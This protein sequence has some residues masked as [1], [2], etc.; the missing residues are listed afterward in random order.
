MIKK[1]LF[2]IFLFANLYV[3]SQSYSIHLQSGVFTPIENNLS[4]VRWSN[5]ELVNGYYYRFIQF[6]NI[7]TNEE[8]K[9]FA[10]HGILLYNYVPNHAFMAAIPAAFDIT[11]LKEE[12]IRSV[13]PIEKN[14]KLEVSLAKKQY[15]GW[16]LK[17]NQKIELV[18]MQHPNISYNQVSQWLR[19]EGAEVQHSIV[20][21]GAHRIIIKIS[22]IEKYA[23]LP[24]LYFLEPFD[25][26]P[27]PDNLVGRS[28]HRSNMIA[29]DYFGGLKYDGTGVKIALND[30]GVIGPHIDY[31]GR[32]I[33]QF[34]G[35]NNGNH[36]D[37]C[38]GIIMSAGNR[39]PLGRGMAFGAD[40]GVYGVSGMFSTLYQAFD[41]IYSHYNKYEIRITSTSYSNGN[42]AGYT[43]LAQLMDIHINDMPDLMHVFS[44]GNA[45]ASDFGYGAGA[46]WGNITGGH[47]QAKN[48]IATGNVTY[49]D[50]LA[51]S[52]SRGPAHD[53]RIKPD[54][55]AV[56]TNVLS[57]IDPDTYANFTGTSMAC[58]GIAGTL[59]QLYQAYKEL[60]NGNNPSSALIK[61][62]VLN[63]ADDLGN[64]GPDYKHGWGRI[65]ARRAYS[66]IKN[67]Q[68]I[69][70]MI[71]QGGNKTHIITVPNGVSELRIM[72]YWH[73]FE[74]TV[75]VSKA[76][77]NNLD[78]TVTTPS[79]QV[80][81]PW[82]L[83]PTP[84]PVNLNTPAV[85]GVDT[86]NNVEQV[87]ITNPAA[88][89]YTVTI[90]GTQVPQG[91]Q[92]YYVVYE[93]VTDDLVLTYPSGG[94]SIVPGTQETI[95]WDAFGNSG[96]FTLEYSTDNG[97]TWNTIASGIAAAQRYYD[98]N[99]PTVVTGQAL[100][101]VSR[102]AKSDVSDTNFSIIGVPSNIT[103]DWVCIDSMQVSYGA[104]SGATGY[105][106]SILGNKYM[107]SVGYSTTT[108][109]VVKNINTFNPGWFSVH[110]LGANNCVGRRAIAQPYQ[111]VPYNCVIPDDIVMLNH[112]APNSTTILNCQ[113][114]A[115]P[116]PVS[117]TIKNAGLTPASNITVKY[118][119]NGGS[120]VAEVYAG[121]INANTSVVYNFVQGATL[122]SPGNYE[123]KAW[124]EHPNNQIPTNDTTTW[125]KNVVSQPVLPLPIF[126]DFET[127][128]LCGT[129][130]NCSNENCAMSNGWLNEFNNLTD[131]IDWRTNSGPTPTTNTGPAMDF[132]PGTLDGKY[133]YIEA[134]SCFNKPAELISPCIEIASN[135][136]AP[137]MSFAYHMW[138]SDMG[139][140]HVDVFSDGVWNNDVIP[141]FTGD[142]GN[143][144]NTAVV[145]LSAYIGK[146]INIR[147]R[148]ISG[149]NFNS[150]MAL[151]AISIT[152]PVGLNN[153]EPEM[154]MQLFPNPTNGLIYLEIYRVPSETEI[155]ITDVNG[156][157]VYK[158]KVQP[159][160]N[161]VN[162]TINLENTNAG[163]YFITIKNN[164]GIINK[165]LLKF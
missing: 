100:V 52:S 95:R 116:F 66:I 21:Q 135:L 3:F 61:A 13:F 151:D 97:N 76:L 110:A 86:L 163:I 140:L 139:E 17:T 73:D 44:A 125:Y 84:N 132:L 9:Y 104:V 103:V 27:Q 90:N 50:V 141:V 147:F 81:L 94:E 26:N 107:D 101:R 137:E 160:G 70:D 89:N 6:K 126:E 102:G 91:P 74:A 33:N 149:A 77:V 145:P 122:S 58:P 31:Q 72:V 32:L 113:P 82:V 49:Q 63:T 78:L 62:S 152:D 164:L 138:G 80:V 115:N 16:A 131:S 10:A 64:P 128:S 19:N 79:S 48:V 25:S 45:G 54:I 60:N 37:H 22:E 39:N 98:W 106:V 155:L 2:S 14:N 15:P 46:G 35:F 83:D 143:T 118:A 154:I 130:S 55:C 120:P 57:T 75:G 53:G 146:T 96:T 133:V 71:S 68:Y 18:V 5:N 59:G 148:G 67:N 38:A 127:F 30:D 85:Q 165:K 134:S 92:E 112:L 41:S 123:F 11:Q 36:G 142:K 93:F 105:L 87:T 51:N 108:T 119:V 4:D 29:T 40:L 114:V 99:P 159:Y 56:G 24:Y 161:T 43:S 153:Q 158:S 157:I 124:I 42:N 65:N 1:T 162:T 156:K 88:G 69:S 8:K 47:K 12:N 34:I 109:C 20:R 28:D 136:I 111:A 150:D 144:W 7:P 121:P 129:T 23:L 117:V